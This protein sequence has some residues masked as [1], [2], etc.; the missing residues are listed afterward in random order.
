MSWL[1]FWRRSKRSSG[2]A[3]ADPLRTVNGR[4]FVAG[5]PYLLPKDM[6]ETNRLDFQHYMLRYALRGNYAAPVE[7]P[8]DILDVGCGTGRWAT[9]MA[10]EFP[11]A[12]VIGVDVAPPPMDENVAN[13]LHADNYTFVQ[14]NALERLPFPD[15]SFDFV[16]QRLLTLAI[17]EAQWPGAVHELARV[18]RRGGWIEMVEGGDRFDGSPAMERISD[19]GQ[20][21]LRRRGIN[22]DMV[23]HLGEML[24]QAGAVDVTQRRVDL[25]I[26]KHGGRI[27]AMVETNT[28]TALVAL[29]APIASL[30]IADADAFDRTLAQARDEIARGHFVVP[31][32]IAYGRIPS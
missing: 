6:G 17:P 20:G 26:G 8:R 3:V 19:W 1:A 23:R 24:Q 9:E 4:R 14:G 12:N 30:G 31:F 13:K 32:Y 2:A 28:M 5:V 16:H 18:T 21:L 29:R 15:G 22:S 27:G 25:P 10:T 7:Q 11:N